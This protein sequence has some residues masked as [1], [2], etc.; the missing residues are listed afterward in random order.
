MFH[1]VLFISCNR[2]QDQIHSSLT[3]ILLRNLRL[4]I[5]ILI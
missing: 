5:H 1:P 2:R 3:H 4:R